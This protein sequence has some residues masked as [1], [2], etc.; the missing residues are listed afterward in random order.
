MIWRAARDAASGSAACYAYAIFF[1]DFTPPPLRRAG[2]F[3]RFSSFAIARFRHR[4]CAAARHFIAF[5]TAF[6]IRHAAAT[7]HFRRRRF[8]YFAALADAAAA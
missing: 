6:A 5:A 3:S 1:R 4:Y 8:R 2:F 7:G